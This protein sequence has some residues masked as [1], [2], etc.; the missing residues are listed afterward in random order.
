MTPEELRAALEHRARGQWELYRK[1]AE[2]RTLEA[3][4]ALRRTAWRREQGWAAR[5]WE[6]GGPRFAAASSPRDLLRALPSAGRIPIA[7]EPPPE[8]PAHASPGPPA[9]AVEPPADLF[10]EL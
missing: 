3:S 4:P 10:E 7:S 1:S 8:W 5:W 6:S 9:A 2:S